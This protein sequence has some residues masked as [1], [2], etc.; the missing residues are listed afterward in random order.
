[1]NSISPVQSVSQL[2]TLMR[3]WIAEGAVLN[4]EP[5]TRLSHD[6]IPGAYARSL[7]RP[8]GTL[9][10]GKAHRHPCFNFL[11]EGK[12]SIWS[13]EGQRDVDAGDFWISLGEAK[14]V[15][16]A[17]MDSTLIT[18]HP[19]NERDLD[20]LEAELIIPDSEQPDLL[21]VLKQLV[22]T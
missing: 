21:T 22:Q 17:H 9:I 19:T 3:A 14:R 11:S 12:M 18:I 15:T 10:V 2:E 6:F 16:F 5:L 20:R 8:K 1:M 4:A 13:K 7:W